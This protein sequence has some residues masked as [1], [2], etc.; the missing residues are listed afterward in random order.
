MNIFY[1]AKK[2]QQSLNGNNDYQDP[3]RRPCL[4]TCRKL[5]TATFIVYKKHPKWGAFLNWRRAQDCSG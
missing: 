2:Q 3:F 5:L 4:K 1:K